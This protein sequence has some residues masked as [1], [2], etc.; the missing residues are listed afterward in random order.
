MRP[1]FEEFEWKSMVGKAEPNTVSIV[2]LDFSL[3]KNDAR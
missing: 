2:A 1:A 3:P